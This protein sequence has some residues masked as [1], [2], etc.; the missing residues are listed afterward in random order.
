MAD[1]PRERVS[2]SVSD[3]AETQA[4]KSQ[5]GSRCRLGPGVG[6][7]GLCT[8]GSP[9]VTDLGRGGHIREVVSLETGPVGQP[10]T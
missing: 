1:L 5:K 4:A 2:V 8:E 10:P 6:A 9:S 7:G 3:V